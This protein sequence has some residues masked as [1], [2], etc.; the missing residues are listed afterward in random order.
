MKYGLY[1][2]ILF[3]KNVKRKGDVMFLTFVKKLV[4]VSLLVS[5][6][7]LGYFVM[8]VGLGEYNHIEIIKQ[9][10]ELKPVP[11]YFLSATGVI[12]IMFSFLMFGIIASISKFA[13]VEVPISRL[14]RVI[15]QDLILFVVDQDIFHKNAIKWA[16]VNLNHVGREIGRNFFSVKLSD[17][18]YIKQPIGDVPTQTED[19]IPAPVDEIQELDLSDLEEFLDQEEPFELG[20]EDK[21][22]DD[23]NKEEERVL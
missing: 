7:V 14:S 12:M 9:A 4:V 6:I 5:G 21:E 2:H 10:V 18:I 15:V 19:M 16:K 1:I 20:A 11:M 17:R 8:L 13:Y 23:N 22:H 3:S